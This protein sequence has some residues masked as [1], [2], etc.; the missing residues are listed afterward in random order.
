MNGQ[1]NIEFSILEFFE[2]SCLTQPFDL[3]RME[4]QIAAA[5]AA[6]STASDYSQI[7][8]W[9][10]QWQANEPR[11]LLIRLYAAQLQER[12]NRLEA[13]E[14]NYLELLK[15]TPSSKIMSQARAGIQRVQQQQ[16]AIKAKA[17]SEAKQVVGGDEVSILAIAAPPASQ[18]QQTL[19]G[20]AK[21]FDLDAYTARLKVPASGFRIHRIGPWGEI[22]FFAQAL[23]QVHVTTLAVQVS[24]VKAL[25]IFQICYFEAIAPQPIVIC[26][27]TAGQLG[28]LEFSWAEITQ[29]VSGQLPIF[30]Q[31]AD[32]GHW[33]RTVHQ[34][35]VQDYIQVIDFHLKERQ[36][37]LRLCDRLY[38]YQKGVSLTQQSELNSRILWNHLQ[39]HLQQSI[40]ASHQND[41]SR[42]SKGALEFIDI[43]P[44]IHPYL[45][46]D[47]RAPSHWD[48]AFHLYSGLCYFE[49]SIQKKHK[50][51]QTQNRKSNSLSS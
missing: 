10:K 32:I 40:K 7:A 16:A 27:N 5:L 31:V 23:K 14:K 29:Q 34:E 45:D 1:P 2:F 12:T 13:A 30:E 37:V 33:G 15:Q 24:K 20:I 36:I 51:E 11:N 26:K 9:L 48:Q 17:L 35:K 25:P 19:E 47:R 44:P 3:N 43:L 41:F 46:I 49:T 28:R 4:A 42:F 8:K 18:R 6:A 21:V 50:L 38:Q 22:S 39:A